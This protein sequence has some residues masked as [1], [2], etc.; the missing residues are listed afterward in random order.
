MPHSSIPTPKG[1]R[2]LGHLA[3]FKKNPLDC[4][5]RWQREF[6]DIVNFRILSQNFYLLS[7]PDL[8]E[9]AMTEQ[10]DVFVKIYDPQ[11][12][13]G[14]Q[15]F[16]GQGLVTSTGPLWN[17]QRRLLQPVFQRRNILT[18]LPEME[19]AGAQ[20]IARWRQL[21]PDTEVDI[22]AEMLHLALEVLTRTMFSTSVLDRV[23]VIAPALEVCLRYAAATVLNPLDPPLWVPTRR[24]REFK[25]AL[26]ALDSI[27]YGLIDE[28]TANPGR[29]NDLLHLL[30]T[31]TDPET[32]AGMG[33]RQ[34]RDEMATLF[35]AGH[36][37]SANVLTWT[38]YHLAKHPEVMA[39]LRAELH[40]VLNGGIPSEDQL[41]Q[42]PY[43]KAV[44]FEAMRLK[45]A[46]ALMIRKIGRDTR[47]Q[48]YPLKAGSLAMISIYNIHHHP[49][50]WENPEAFDPDRFLGQKVSKYMF[51]PFGI[52]PRFC[53][54]NQFATVELTLLLAMLAQHF[55]FA[56]CSDQEPEHDMAVTLRPKGGL[57]LR[58]RAI[59]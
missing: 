32:G 51:L 4:M 37:T 34:L 39:R 7:H 42:L 52:G 24:N 15:L 38:L 9:Q 29:Y 20:L 31:S 48:N 44:L 47:L 19:K 58:V 1:Q 17:Q 57:R 40:R 50:L 35:V 46:V 2:L 28:R 36:E 54:G 43:T 53:I 5:I 56:L 26:A 10:Q 27:I 3:E 59:N 25:R 16:M 6:G 11:K 30:L 33:R 12:P 8:V 13:K 23:D 14:L 22:S 21:A 45:P 55:D 18:L 41:D 49:A